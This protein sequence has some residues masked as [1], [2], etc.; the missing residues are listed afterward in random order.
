M[1]LAF[2]SKPSKSTKAPWFLRLTGDILRKDGTARTAG[3]TGKDGLLTRAAKGIVSFL[4]NFLPSPTQKEGVRGGQSAAFVQS[5]T[6]VL[7]GID[8]LALPMEQ[9]QA[10][11]GHLP[12]VSEVI[13]DWDVHMSDDFDMEVVHSD[14]SVPQWAEVKYC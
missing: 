12:F 13:I 10:N 9:A 6:A 14:G 4:Q 11:H 8:L 2:W 7:V 5:A 1:R 3:G